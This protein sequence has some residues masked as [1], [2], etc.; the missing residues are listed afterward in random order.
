MSLTKITSGRSSSAAMLLSASQAMPP[1]S[2]PSPTSATTV[3][4]FPRSCSP[5]AM[6]AAYE[7]EVDACELSTQSCSDSARLG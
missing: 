5:R 6:P 2:A 3:P 1:V 7:S 4:D